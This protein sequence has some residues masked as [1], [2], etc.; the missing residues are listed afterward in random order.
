MRDYAT[1]RSPVLTKGKSGRVYEDDF[2]PSSTLIDFHKLT[3]HDM[4]A[5]LLLKFRQNVM[6]FVEKSASPTFFR[7]WYAN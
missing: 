4:L 2:H 6:F 7:F 5:C 1:E 3:P